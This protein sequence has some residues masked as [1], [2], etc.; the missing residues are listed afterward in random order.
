MRSLEFHY[1]FKYSFETVVHAYFQKVIIICFLE[2][3][4]AQLH[5]IRF[6][7]CSLSFDL[8]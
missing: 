2:H 4:E 7:M 3:F 1:L 5:N 6:S 8:E